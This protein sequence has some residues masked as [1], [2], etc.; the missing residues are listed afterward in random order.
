MPNTT[1]LPAL[2]PSP[3]PVAPRWPLLAGVLAA[4]IVTMILY[5]DSLG[6]PFFQDD[7]I[8]IR[9]LSWHSLI[10][11]W[12]T[13]EAMPDYR[14]LGRF[15]IKLWWLL[16]GYHDEAWLRFH[17]IGLHVVNSALVGALATRLSRRRER[18]VDGGLAAALFAASPWAF[19]AVPW[20]NVFFY[21]LLMALLMLMVL[22]YWE[23]RTRRQPA[24][25]ALAVFLGA[26]APFEIE[27]GLMACGLLGLL[28]AVWWL[29]RRQK[30][31]W[32]WAAVVV[33]LLNLGALVIWLAQPR[34]EY[35]FGP[36]TLDGLWQMG[37]IFLQGLITPVAPL[38]NYLVE[39]TPEATA[40]IAVASL[41]ILGVLCAWLIQRGRGWMALRAVG[42]FG[43]MILP[44]LA[45][46]N[47]L[48]VWNS[49]RLMYLIAPA[50]GWLWGGALAGWIEGAEGK[51]RRGQ[52]WRAVVAVALVA[53]SMA[54]SGVYVRQR[55]RLYDMAAEASRG[56]AA[57]A[58][59]APTGSIPLFVNLP[60]WISPAKRIYPLGDIGI[61]WM[62]YYQGVDDVI[63]AQLECD[64]HSRAVIF[65]NVQT[66]QPYYWGLYGDGP[67]SW[68]DLRTELV[69]ND[70]VYL[71]QYSA[72][73]IWLRYVGMVGDSACAAGNPVATFGAAAVLECAEVQI[74]PEENELVVQLG[75]Q[76]Y[77]PDRQDLTV[78]VH[79]AGPE[80]LVAQGDGDPLL[81]LAPFWLWGA[82]GQTLTDVRYLTLGGLESQEY[83]LLVGIYNRATAER[84][85]ARDIAGQPLPDNAVEVWRGLIP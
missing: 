46:L 49:P 8:H 1:F 51:A 63:F 47:F 14:P 54:Q 25:I 52:I 22:L 6:L 34:N 68:E 26:L 40:V 69:E 80:G 16:L 23:G 41:L 66:A 37:A 61:Q 31:P 21:P 35:S 13:A 39:P 70:P 27:H 72:E 38:L 62:P 19:Q 33:F 83:R 74:D 79:L 85:E 65:E 71:T 75:W 5:G 67:L 76:V 45:S 24:L 82:A 44:S 30:W 36:R 73:R 48:Y 12:L 78:F 2:K 53:S 42:W 32:P 7:T 15:I 59:D 58:T 18:T 60:S 81:G 57:A 10:D 43:L 29:E 11:T 64:H 84:L 77:D 50:T 56:V 4:G 55:A 3:K 28:E 17:N 20:I 9:W